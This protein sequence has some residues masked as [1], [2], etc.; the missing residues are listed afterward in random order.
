MPVILAPQNLVAV[1]DSTTGSSSLLSSKISG[2]VVAAPGVLDILK[3]S[4][5]CIL[6]RGAGPELLPPCEEAILHWMDQ[7]QVA[8]MYK[9][10]GNPNPPIEVLKLHLKT[11]Q[12]N[13]R[14]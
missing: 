8:N 9:F 7:H 3:A 2:P 4:R 10:L 13:S 5:L 6:P 11:L 1:P 12:W 14:N